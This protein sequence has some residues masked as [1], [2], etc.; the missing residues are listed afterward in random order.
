[1]PER[2]HCSFRPIFGLGA[3]VTESIQNRAHEAQDH[4][5]VVDHQ[6]SAGGIHD[7]QTQKATGAGLGPCNAT[8]T[9]SVAVE[10]AASFPAKE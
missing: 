9:K 4:F 2:I 5:L 8:G 3:F 7:R 6:D 1:L 10:V